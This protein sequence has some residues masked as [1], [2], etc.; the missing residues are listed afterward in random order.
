MW[1]SDSYDKAKESGLLYIQ[2]TWPG[3][4]FDAL[5]HSNNLTMTFTWDNKLLDAAP[6]N[7]KD[8]HTL[9]V[10]KKRNIVQRILHS[11]FILGHYEVGIALIKAIIIVSVK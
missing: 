7:S 3:V 4:Q 1:F 5:C 9:M 11:H 10:H 8:F 6:S 2:I